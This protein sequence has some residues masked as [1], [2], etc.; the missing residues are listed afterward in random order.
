VADIDVTVVVPV[1][2]SGPAIDSCIDSLMA[3]TL[4]ADRLQLVF[5]DDGSTDGT[6]D[7]LDRLAARHPHV[8]VIHSPNSGWP[9]RPRNLGIDAATGDYIQFVDHDDSL[10]PDALAR[11]V[12]YGR[13]NHADIVIGRVT[14]NFRPTPNGLFRE[15]HPA[16]SIRDAQLIDSL[17]PHKMFRRQFLLDTGIRYPEGKVRLE[18][19]LFMVK[20]YFAAASVAVLSE[21]PCYFY[22]RRPEG[23]HAADEVVDPAVYYGY[24]REVLDVI[25]ANTEPGELRDELY[26]R[27][28]RTMVRRAGNRLASSLPA[29]YVDAYVTAVTSINTDYFSAA[30]ADGLTPLRRAQ[31]VALM[32]GRHE[33]VV[34]VAEQ[35]RLPVPDVQLDDL[36]WTGTAWRLAL[37]LRMTA[38]DGS[39]IVVVPSG[40]G[41]RLDPRVIPTEIDVRADSRDELLARSVADVVVRDRHSGMRWFAPGE[42]AARLEPVADGSLQMIYTGEVE[43]DPMTLAL[44]HPLT[45]GTWDVAVHYDVF[46]LRRHVPIRPEP[47][48]A[49]SLRPLLLRPPARVVRP[50][51]GR[52][53]KLALVVQP[54]AKSLAA[55]MTRYLGDVSLNGRVLTAPVGLELVGGPATTTGEVIVGADGLRRPVTIIA[56]GGGAELRCDLGRRG[57]PAGESVLALQVR[58]ADRPVPFAVLTVGRLG[59]ISVV[60]AATPRD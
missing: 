55:V 26:R 58:A 12:D 6:G 18:D 56:T 19:Q 23:E 42:L 54:P 52:S 48:V 51:V 24:L 50:T 38:T 59:R 40:D 60:A 33:Q 17:T 10:A 1:Y 25:A 32:A 27:F 9:G 30:V 2:N 41:Y 37:T 49:D 21:F 5:S 57:L 36:R 28:Y 29:A 34:A 4:P 15:N 46:G 14:S 3:Q 31:S 39:P 35:S 43:L 45:P 16:C 44:G 7:K 11:L 53:G 22:R 13:T 47:S 20:T 8:E